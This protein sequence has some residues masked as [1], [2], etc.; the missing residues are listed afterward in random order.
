MSAQNRRTLHRRLLRIGLLARRVRLTRALTLVLAVSA[1]I[2]VGATAAV[3]MGVGPTVNDPAVMLILL[4]VNLVIMLALGV[5]VARRLVKV[6]MARRSGGAGSRLHVRLVVLFG[7]VAVTPAILTS[8]FSI[9]IFQAGVQSWFS[10]RVSTALD[11]S[12]SVAQ[13]YLREHQQV[14]SG[15]VLAIAN[16]LNRD[17]LR[18]S[19]NPQNLNQFLSAQSAL[20]NLTEAVIFGKDGKVI[21][22]AGYT[23]SLQFEQVPFWA[24]DRADTGD[25]AILTGENDDRVRG[26]VRLGVDSLNPLYLYVGRFVDPQVLGAIE[27]TEAAVNQYRELEGRR[28]GYELTLSMIFIMVSVL[29]LLAAVAVGLTMATR[30]VQPIMAL[31]EAADRV[32]QG[33][34]RVRVREIVANDEVASLS[35]AFNRMT[36]QIEAQQKSLLAANQELD[37]R[38]RFTET[39]LAGVSAGVVAL[40]RDGLVTLGNPPASRLLGEALDDWCGRP[41]D[42]LMPAIAS[43]IEQC[44]ARPD[45]PAQAEMSHGQGGRTLTLLVRVSAERDEDGDILGYVL[46]FDDITELQQAQRKAAWADVARRIAHEIKNPLTPIQLS[47]ERLKRRYLK[48]LTH[49]QDTFVQ[50]TDTIVRHVGDIGQMVDEFS[51]F[52]RMPAPSMRPERL[53]EIVRQAVVLQRTAYTRIAFHTD[54]PEAAVKMHCDARQ[55]SQALTNL[56]KNAVEGIDGRLEK[57]KDQATEPGIITVRVEERSDETAIVVEDNGKGLPDGDRNRLTEPYVTTRSKGTGLGLAIVRKILEDHGGSLR[58]DD[59]PGGGARV[60][61]VIP[62]PE[63]LAPGDRDAAVTADAR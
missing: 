36:A 2:S 37:E 20:R 8:V 26:L 54:L 50:C 19:R 39:V 7:V 52:A 22:R 47:A 60:S 58:L 23:Y 61:M 3:L 10:S 9:L 32:R 53:D 51:A 29:L 62:R 21:A 45:R 42:V 46:T 34:L 38:R 55:I 4:N 33:N 14:I 11:E 5:L 59:R 31:I 6:W 15:D 18:A 63:E 43:L 17:W 44:R 56:L 12:L 48:Q 28:S 41:V 57:E 24:M 49:D 40:D 35:R 30:L 27:S 16:D 25:V 13:A 1:V